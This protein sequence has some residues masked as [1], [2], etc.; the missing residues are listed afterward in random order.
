MVK[1]FY[2]KVAKKF[3]DYQ[4]NTRIINEFP[5]GNPEAIFKQ[6]L[7]ELSGKNKITLDSGCADGVF[8][9]SIAPYFKKIIA[10]DTSKGMLKA[11]KKRQLESKMTNIEF[12]KQN[13]HRMT[14]VANF[15]DVI[16]NRRGQ[17]DFPL[18][19]KTLKPKGYYIAIDI[20]E[21]DTQELKEIFGRGQNF[22]QWNKS[23]L[24]KKEKQLKKLGFKIIYS[25]DFF[26]NEYYLTDQDLD[27]FLQGVPIFEDY[28]SQKDR[29]FLRRYLKEFKQKKGINLPRH[30]LV[31]LAQKL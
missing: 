5:H 9:L 31:I 11:A 29:K 2:D 6:K 22:G 3:G 20:G 8:T 16:Y 7:L 27:I 26:Y 1:N 18:F 17:E 23:F 25:G 24:E 14:F 10:I 12:V 28:D 30:R 21:K 13:V 19:Y 4:N 15:F